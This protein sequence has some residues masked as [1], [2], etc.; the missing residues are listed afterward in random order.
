M[1]MAMNTM[2]SCCRFLPRFCFKPI[3]LIQASHITDYSQKILSN[4]RYGS[5]RHRLETEISWYP[6]LK[7]GQHLGSLNLKMSS[8]INNS[9]DV[10][11]VSPDT[12]CD[13]L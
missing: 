6:L 7:A 9:T 3:I 5:I 10:L 13:M 12:T 2:I 8:T 4:G 11:D 1:N